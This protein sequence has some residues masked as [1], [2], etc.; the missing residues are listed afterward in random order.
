MNILA[1]LALLFGK[2]SL[3]AIGGATSTLPEIAREVV[4]ERHWFTPPQFVQVFAISNAAPGPNVLVT[5]M[6][7]ARMAG[8]AGGVVAT[9]AMI[10]PAGLL[11]VA[12]SRVWERYRAARWRRIIQSALLPMTAGLVLAAGGVLIRQADTGIA[13]AAITLVCAMVTWQTK[14]HPLWLLGGGTIVGLILGV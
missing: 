9:L 3:L 4:A 13:T 11:A 2:L 12:V 10:L 14:I 8:V 6:I 7:G 5:T 1:Q